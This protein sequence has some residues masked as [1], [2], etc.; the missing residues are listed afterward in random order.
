MFPAIQVENLSKQY[1]IGTQ[2]SAGYQTLRESLTVATSTAWKRVRR[3]QRSSANG[4]SRGDIDLLWALNDVSFDV[5]PGEVVGIIGRNGAGKSTLLKILSRITE[6]TFGRATIRGRIGSLLEVGTGFHP[7]LTGRENVYM[8]GSTLGMS[9]REITRRFDEIV[10]FADVERFLETPVKRYSSGMYVRL[11]F[12]V[13]AHMD[14]EILFIDEVLAVGDSAFQAKCMAKMSAIRQSGRTILFVSHNMAAVAN[15]CSRSVLVEAGRLRYFGDT[16][17][18]LRRY[19]ASAQSSTASDLDLTDHHARTA[20]SQPLIRR[21]RFLNVAGDVTN[22]VCS[23]DTLE[24]EFTIDA[25]ETTDVPRLS[26]GFDDLSGT[27]LFSVST[28]LSDSRLP[29]LS[30]K[31]RV[32]CTIPQLP[33][34]PGRYL[35]SLGAGTLYEPGQDILVHAA[36]LD[37]DGGDFYGAGQVPHE[38]LGRFL[39]R[40]NWRVAS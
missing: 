19:S 24:L 27:R 7:E 30:S 15:L 1:L 22:R 14:T 9:R 31:S 20:G 23:G 39:V 18:C 4:R 36:S 25:M 3:R 17:S 5:Q 40:S 16:P 34:A 2:R 29:Q 10:H 26:V 35:L 33:L 37:V 11:A 32:L 12:A 13:A 6:P 8:N 38:G 28:V 21:L